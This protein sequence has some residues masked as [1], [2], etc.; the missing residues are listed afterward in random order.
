MDPVR[1]VRW[2]A[3][4]AGLVAAVEAVLPWTAGM[5][6]DEGWWLAVLA[7]AATA[8]VVTPNLVPLAPRWVFGLDLAAAI[9]ASG[10][11]LDAAYYVGHNSTGYEQSGVIYSAQLRS[12]T[13][14]TMA[15]AAAGLML[16]ALL[17]HGSTWQHLLDTSRARPRARRLPPVSAVLLE[18]AVV[19]GGAGLLAPVWADVC[20]AP[21]YY[22]T[23]AGTERVWATADV[24]VLAALLLANAVGARGTAN[25]LVALMVLSTGLGVLGLAHGVQLALTDP[26]RPLTFGTVAIGAGTVLRIVAL[27]LAWRRRPVALAAAL[28]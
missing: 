6:A 10:L 27:V 28:V 3:V 21:Q 18:A 19:A 5:Q 17:A 7:L 14:F 13:V 9:G 15:L 16:C 12:A 2:V 25:L 22:A 1:I 20:A 8:A 26:C 4:P 24:A 23:F 11:T